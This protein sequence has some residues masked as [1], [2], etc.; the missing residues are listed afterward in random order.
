MKLLGL[1]T[2][3]D[4]LLY[5]LIINEK[6]E[7]DK[8]TKNGWDVQILNGYFEGISRKRADFF[9]WLDQQHLMGEVVDDGIWGIILVA[10]FSPKNAGEFLF[11]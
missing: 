1:Q 10:K 7:L 11:L 4:E 8:E 6:Y 3:Y 9:E 5:D 2:V